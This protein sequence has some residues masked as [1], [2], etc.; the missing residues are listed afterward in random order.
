MINTFLVGQEICMDGHLSN[1]WT[2]LHNLTL[3]SSLILSET[4][5]DNF[6]ELIVNSALIAR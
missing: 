1:D 5:I 6:I 3:Y 2:I 4:V